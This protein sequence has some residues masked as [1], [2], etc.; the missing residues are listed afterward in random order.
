[1]SHAE[2]A[3]CQRS[4]TIGYFTVIENA[5]FGWTGGILIL[6]AGGR[7]LEFR[8]T[9]PLRTN[10]SQE[11]LY[12]ATLRS[13][14]IAETIAP[15]LRQACK[16]PIGLLCCQQV[17]AMKATSLATGNKGFADTIAALVV[18]V[19][20]DD[21]GPITKE[22]LPGHRPVT[23]LDSSLLVPS[24]HV[25]DTQEL[26][27]ELTDLPDALEPFDRINEAIREAQT[28]IAKAA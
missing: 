3:G 26:V 24:Q 11:I 6:N 23:L 28:Q 18:S 8:C 25:E 21:Q 17:E 19:A 16:T 1:M 13:H 20:E 22:R 10:R 9:L 27:R 14:I 7:P 5:H 2:A 15:T 12:G 4:P